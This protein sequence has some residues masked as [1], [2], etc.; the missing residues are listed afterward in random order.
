MKFWKKSMVPTKKSTVA[1]FLLSI[2][3]M[4][5]TYSVNQWLV[6]RIEVRDFTAAIQNDT[7]EN[8]TSAKNLLDGMATDL[9]N[10]AEEILKFDSL[11]EPEIRKILEF[12]H[13]MNLFDVTFVSDMDGN[14][15]DDFGYTFSVADQ[16][17]FIEVKNKQD[18]VFS[19][20]LPS[21]RFGSIQII[22]F[23]LIKD[24]QEPMGVLFGLFSLETFSHLINTAIDE[25]KNAYIVDSNGIYINCF[26]K[27]HMETD[28]GN[29]WDALK[30]VEL[31][32]TTV[33]KL[34]EKF[35]TG[36]EGGFSF[37]DP[38]LNMNRYG[39]HMPLGIQDW[40]IVLTVEETFVNS[41]IR[42]IRFVDTVDLALDVISLSVMLYCV[43]SYFTKSNKAIV[44]VNQEISKSNKM[45]KLAMEYSK[46]I[47]FEYNIENQEIEL[48]TEIADLPFKSAVI[49]GVPD[50]FF[51]QGMIM[52][53]SVDALKT[54]FEA[55]KKEKSSQADIQIR[56]SHQEKIWYRV[57][58]Y[59]IYDEDGSFIGTVGSAE[60][61]SMLKKGE[62]AIRRRDE[63]YE[64]FLANALLY[65]RV[66]LNTAMVS[67]INGKEKRISYQEYSKRLIKAY[68]C[69]DQQSYVAQALDIETL[70]QEY[71]QGKEYIEVQCLKKEKDG[72]RWVS[73]VVYRVH[74]NRRDSA[75]VMFLIRD[76]DEKKRREIALKEQAERDG[77]TGLYNAVTARAKINEILSKKCTEE[78]N[79]V[80]MLFDLDNFKQ[81]NDSFGHA[82]GDQ[83]LI[84]VS[85]ALKER[86]R[87]SDVIGRLGG[88]EFV[89]MLFDVHSDKYVERVMK[90]LKASI[91]K[92]YIQGERSV[93]LSASIGAALVPNDGMTF[94][95]L[96]NKADKALYEVKNTGKNGYRRYQ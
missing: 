25:G 21:K 23:P 41:H 15:Y 56:G 26:N 16:E 10:T 13:K 19:E 82:C 5:V 72:L 30:T 3:C 75:K 22:G 90:D 6:M 49:S 69:E 65:A 74:M 84:E 40:Q 20:V 93:K 64:S 38:K 60:D 34:Q 88:D 2:A 50:Y 80:F 27:H 71:R 48:K 8:L 95:E 86:F 1:V 14:A 79:H 12:S 91:T 73:C 42:S 28:H 96:Y 45:L 35:H 44:E 94:E 87:A 43:Y 33:G 39:Y 61:I 37:R 67:E 57:R 59:N 18:V 70:R 81:I 76:I 78:G 52:E 58:M 53:D 77:L 29:F 66:N 85:N 54:L 46:H 62:M 17:Y 55:I 31:K 89:V 32:R 24:D 36:Q 68:V 7:R 4:I 47:I 51:D 63:M 83:V 92:N 9:E 11:N